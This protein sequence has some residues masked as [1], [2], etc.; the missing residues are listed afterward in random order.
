MRSFWSEPFLWIHLAGIAALPI[1]LEI[2]WLGL[3][4][5]D[6]ALPV[7]LEVF[8]VAGVGIAPVLWMQL[9]RP[10]D[11]FSLL[12]VA[13]KPEQLTPEQRRILSLF[14][15]PVNRLLASVV[16]VFMLWLFWQMYRTAPGVAVA[17]PWLP[18][19]RLLGLLAASL[20]FLASNLF[21][22]IPISVLGILFSSEQ[23]FAAQ[24]PL[25]VEK[26]AQQFTLL[27]WRVNKILPAM[28]TE[29][30]AGER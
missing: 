25:P 12:V 20:A 27:G 15:T 30:D 28:A 14:K 7:W 1:L 13:M 5:G 19:W 24:E 3:A 6:P 2:C 26:I 16:A 11:I 9:T 18:S 22:Q 29:P 23:A 17:A 10:F 21:L 4:V 8:L